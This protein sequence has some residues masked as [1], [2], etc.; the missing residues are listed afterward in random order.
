[1]TDRFRLRYLKST[2]LEKSDFGASSS[3]PDSIRITNVPP[4]S[5][6]YKVPESFS[7]ETILTQARTDLKHPDPKVRVLAIKYYLER[8]YPSIP[9]SILQE[10]LTDRDPKIRAQVLCFLIKFRS[11]ILAPLLKKYLRDSDPRVRISALRGMFQYQEK[12]DLNLLL[13]FLSD[14]SPWVRR[15]V[16]TLLGW[17][18]IESALPIL[19]ELSRDQ[20][21]M[22]RKAALFSLA[23]LYPEESEDRF[24]EAMTDSD[25]D[26]RK[27][28]QMTLEKMMSRPLKRRSAS[29]PS[30]G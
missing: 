22:V 12:I 25:L 14:D 16:A 7:S 3:N 19:M 26:L 30:R 13:Q 15:K 1:V 4:P 2:G 27:W 11:P 17:T 9:M 6:E 24:I 18:H 23:S 21:S 20:D 29:I 28:A 8:S 10:I 5:T